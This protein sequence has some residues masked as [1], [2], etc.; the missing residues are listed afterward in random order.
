MKKH[1]AHVAA[2][3]AYAPR[4]CIPY[5]NELQ[6]LQMYIERLGAGLLPT[7]LKE[8]LPAAQ[9]VLQSIPAQQVSDAWRQRESMLQQSLQKFPCCRKQRDQVAQRRS[10]GNDEEGKSDVVVAAKMQ[11]SSDLV[12]VS[13]GELA[14]EDSEVQPQD[15][16]DMAADA[17]CLSLPSNQHSQL[18]RAIN[19]WGF[20]D[21]SQKIAR[22]KIAEA[23]TRSSHKGFHQR[24]LA[25]AIQ[26]AV[27]AL[28]APRRKASADAS[29]DE[30]PWMP[31]GLIRAILN[32]SYSG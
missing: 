16:E 14:L 24:E 15:V 20:L 6:L 13:D 4:G 9:A 31:S 10:K 29:I 19:E 1:A 3:I 23:A 7:R 28:A 18:A 30:G 8:V 11:L 27:A 25:E 17:A 5:R 32:H 22:L 12:L 21:E 26:T 2:W